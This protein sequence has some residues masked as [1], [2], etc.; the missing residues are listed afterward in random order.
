MKATKKIAIKKLAVVPVREDWL[1]KYTYLFV[2]YTCNDFAGALNA[3]VSSRHFLE[4]ANDSCPLEPCQFI[5]NILE[6]HPDVE[7]FM[8]VKEES[9]EE[10]V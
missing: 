4:W 8:F 7:Y 3:L 6:E 1:D 2:E 10:V 5:R 9:D